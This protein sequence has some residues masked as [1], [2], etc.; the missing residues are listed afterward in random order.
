MVIIIIITLHRA[1]ECRAHGNLGVIYELLQDTDKAID[2]HQKVHIHCTHTQNM[3]YSLSNEDYMNSLMHMLTILI[4]SII[5]NNKLILVFFTC[6]D[7]ILLW[8]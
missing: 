1:S 8:R 6:R 4:P 7:W 2:H 5:S 3:S